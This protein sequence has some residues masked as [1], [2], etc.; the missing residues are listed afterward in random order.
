MVLFCSLEFAEGII[1]TAE[2]AI[3]TSFSFPVTDFL[4]NAQAFLAAL[5]CPLEFT[6]GFISNAEK[7]IGYCFTFSVTGFLINAKKLLEVLYCCL[8]EVTEGVI[9]SALAIVVG[10]CF[11]FCVFIDLRHYQTLYLFSYNLYYTFFHFEIEV[12]K[13]ELFLC[14]NASLMERGGGEKTNIILINTFEVLKLF[15]I[16]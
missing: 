10:I 4:E 2:I 9:S 12:F 6:E 13:V 16:N 7:V 5:Y 3:G 15:S 11:F 14:S 8:I 1:R